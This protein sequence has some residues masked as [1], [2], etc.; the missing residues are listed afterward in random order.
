MLCPSP[1]SV[2]TNRSTPPTRYANLET[3]KRSASIRRRDA[4]S[5][6]R[7]TSQR[8]QFVRHIQHIGVQSIPIGG[9]IGP[10]L[11]PHSFRD[12]KGVVFLVMTDQPDSNR[13]HA[14]QEAAEEDQVV[15]YLYDKLI[16]SISMDVAC[17][18]HR[19]VKT[20]TYSDVMTP[21]SRM[22]IY[23][24]VHKSREEM[25]ESLERYVTE[26]PVSKR[27]RMASVATSDQNSENESTDAIIVEDIPVPEPT[28]HS[29]IL[30][31]QH[32]IWGR[33]PPKEPKAAAKCPVCSRHIS[34]LRF[35]PHLDKCMGIGTTTRVAAQNHSVVP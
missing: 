28:T 10:V 24:S 29:T 32:D 21:R 1:R 5:P 14:S 34:T 9:L 20:G 6:R 7:V 13:K 18:M 17:G 26:V 27:P 15:Q 4:W 16:D 3:R 12:C 23:P 33:I 8:D 11:L 25:E 30:N 31:T 35:A 22:D 2:G 19:M